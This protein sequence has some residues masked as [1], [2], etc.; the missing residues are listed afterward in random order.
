MK[1][2]FPLIAARPEPVARCWV[3]RSRQDNPQP[4]T[5]AE[6]VGLELS[7]ATGL[8]VGRTDPPR[9]SRRTCKGS[10]VAREGATS[11]L[12][13][14][15]ASSARCAPHER[16]DVA[17]VTVGRPARR[18]PEAPDRCALASTTTWTTVTQGPVAAGSGQRRAAPLA[19]RRAV[20]LALTGH[21]TASTRCGGAAWVT[22]PTTAAS[23]RAR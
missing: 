10:P 15:P 4:E 5:G 3:E 2:G 20:A 1:C 23:P 17:A 19:G 13:P 9:G 22:S 18:L 16:R 8:Q 11:V 14:Q 21:A 12:C 6:P 7:G